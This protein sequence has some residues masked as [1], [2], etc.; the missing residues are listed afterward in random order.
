MANEVSFLIKI[1]TSGEETVRQV[2]MDAA[3]L[4]RVVK[5][6]NDEQGKLNTKLLDINQAH[7]PR[8]FS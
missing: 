3:E 7:P 4:G 6:V 2:T 1:L 5:E 8:D